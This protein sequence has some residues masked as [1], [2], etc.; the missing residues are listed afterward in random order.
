MATHF[1]VAAALA[2]SAL[3]ITACAHSS[4]TVPAVQTGSPQSTIATNA[5]GGTFVRFPLPESNDYSND[6]AN[7]PYS[8]LW[9]TVLPGGTSVI[10]FLKSSGAVRQYFYPMQETVGAYSLISTANAVFGIVEE[11]FRTADLIR[12]TSTGAISTVKRSFVSESGYF[13]NLVVGPDG[14][15]WFAACFPFNGSV[16][17]NCAG[18]SRLVSISPSGVWGPSASLDSFKALQITP[19]PGGN[20]YLSGIQGPNFNTTSVWVVSA[21]G[22]IL[23]KYPLANTTHSPAGIVTGSD[24]NLWITEPALNK[25]ARMTPAGVVTQFNIPTAN[26][27]L[28]RITYGAD[29]ALWFT[30]SLANKIG[31]ITTSGVITAH[32]IPPIPG[33]L[34]SPEGIVVCST[35]AC[36]PHGGVWFTETGFIGKFIAP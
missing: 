33:E 21:N 8:T 1:R 29:G 35:A 10:Q 6:L 19:G 18:G 11:N 27:G 2:L 7:G 3:F 4:N 17:A 23:H 28:A 26:S 13:S 31:R 25:I 22:T 36:P 32:A 24:H 34:P 16:N 15:V 14:R 9:M 30:E 20:L 12:I 5:A